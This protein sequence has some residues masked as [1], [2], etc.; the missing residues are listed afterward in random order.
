MCGAHLALF[1]WCFF[2]V[3]RYVGAV[4]SFFFICIQLLLIVEF[5]HKWNKNWYVFLWEA[6]THWIEETAYQWQRLCSGLHSVWTLPCSPP[7]YCFLSSLPSCLALPYG[8][9]CVNRVWVASPVDPVWLALLWAK[10]D[11]TLDMRFLGSTP[12]TRLKGQTSTNDTV[13]WIRRS[14]VKSVDEIVSFLKRK[15]VCFYFLKHT[16][17]LYWGNLHP[18]VGSCLAYTMVDL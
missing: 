13:L 8:P 9:D 16:G 15:I 10:Y 12:P 18:A 5:A 3:W 2:A 6:L 11:C 1:G 17:S 14:S 7:Q 4:G